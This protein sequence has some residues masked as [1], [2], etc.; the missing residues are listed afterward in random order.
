MITFECP[1]CGHR[2][3]V[4]ATAS[5]KPATASQG[6]GAP[7]CP[8]HGKEWRHNSRGAYCA[9]KLPDGTWCQRKP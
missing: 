6:S 7:V 1:S 9:T 4:G 3:T 5:Q 8:D 2:E